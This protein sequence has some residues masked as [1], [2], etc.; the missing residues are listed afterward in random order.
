MVGSSRRPFHLHGNLG[1]SLQFL[2]SS[3]VGGAHRPHVLQPTSR[4]DSP[5]KFRRFPTLF[6]CV[7][8]AQTQNELLRSTT[9]HTLLWHC[10]GTSLS[11]CRMRCRLCIQPFQFSL[12]LIDGSTVED[13]W[14]VSPPST[15]SLLS[16]LPRTS[17]PWHGGS[18][19]EC[20][21]LSHS[22]RLVGECLV[23]EAD[24]HR[25]T[26]FQPSSLPSCFCR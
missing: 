20:V 11:C 7:L 18:P 17:P 15:L 25:R 1:N 22:H 19:R 2:A 12:T 26:R 13:H 5:C 24:R 23:E 3:S 14:S 9:F 4:C 16:R 8:F 6:V 21:P 10:A